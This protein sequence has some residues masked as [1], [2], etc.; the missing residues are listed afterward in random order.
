MAD[1]ESSQD[2]K[3]LKVGELSR[4]ASMMP[5]TIRYYVRMGLL[6]PHGHSPGGYALF[7]PDRAM[8]RLER[9]QDLKGQRYRLNEIASILAGEASVG[10]G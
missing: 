4:L 9:I 8:R 1:K 7:D 3:L 2:G 10:T 6:D 5:S